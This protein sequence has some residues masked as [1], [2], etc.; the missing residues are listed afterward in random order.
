MHELAGHSKSLATATRRLS[1]TR[2]GDGCREK[3]EVA[4]SS[5][6]ATLAC[7]FTKAQRATS[8]CLDGEL[9]PRERSISNHCAALL[10]C[11]VA[12]QAGC[13][14]FESRVPLKENL[15]DG[16]RFGTSPRA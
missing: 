2:S 16:G 8:R 6:S 10:S 5:R 12:S 3:L 7:L 1:E 13:R 14:G 4:S 11:S 15:S 9:T